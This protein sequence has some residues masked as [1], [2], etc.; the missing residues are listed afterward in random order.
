METFMYI[1]GDIHYLKKGKLPCFFF[2]FSL[3]PAAFLEL[4]RRTS[5]QRKWAEFPHGIIG[6][7]LSEHCLII[8]WRQITAAADNLCLWWKKAKHRMVRSLLQSIIVLI[9]MQEESIFFNCFLFFMSFF[10]TFTL[11]FKH[12][13]G[14]VVAPKGSD[15]TELHLEPWK[16][17]EDKR[18]QNACEGGSCL[19]LMRL[20]SEIRVSRSICELRQTGMNYTLGVN[21]IS[22]KSVS[23]C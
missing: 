15:T 6:M 14:A 5:C 22:T 12:T 1:S 16:S 10:C 8:V 19:P 7:I 4:M 11:E 17:E 9:R 13:E 20:K 2:F 3:S 18:L 21:V 23:G